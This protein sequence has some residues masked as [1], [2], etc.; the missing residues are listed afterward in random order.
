MARVGGGVD[1]LQE[2][3]RR[4][5]GDTRWNSLWFDFTL[6]RLNWLYRTPDLYVSARRRGYY[7]HRS[8]ISVID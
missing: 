4:V 7:E 3:M 2:R 8:A 6:L 5:E 1:S